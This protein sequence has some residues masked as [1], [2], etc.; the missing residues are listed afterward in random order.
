MNYCIGR[1]F[2]IIDNKINRFLVP[3]IKKRLKNKSM[4]LKD[5]HNHY[6]D[7]LSTKKNIKNYFYLWKKKPLINIA[8]NIQFI[9]KNLAKK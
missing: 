5:N 4:C 6:R 2:S 9:T 1:I 3:S 8:G 7:F